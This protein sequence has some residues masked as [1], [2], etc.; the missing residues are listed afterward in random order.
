MLV[1]TSK[2]CGGNRQPMAKDQNSS[3][4]KRLADGWRWIVRQLTVVEQPEQMT[5]GSLWDQEQVGVR[6][7]SMGVCCHRSGRE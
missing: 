5:F 2:L 3:I 6:W 1:L 4:A 7:L